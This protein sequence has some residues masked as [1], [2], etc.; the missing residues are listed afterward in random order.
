M[1]KAG[2]TSAGVSAAKSHSGSLAGDYAVTRGVLK[3]AG[4]VMVERSDCLLPV[5]EALTLLPPLLTRRIALLSEGGGVITVAAEALAERGMTLAPLSAETQRKLKAIVPN[6]SALSNPVDA[7][8]GTDPRAEYY[9]Q[10]GRAILED[11]NVDALM[12]TGFFGGYARRYGAEVAATENRVCLE[13]A[14][15]MRSLGKA[16][17]VQSHYAHFRTEAL[18][19]LRKAGIP[20]YRHIEI[21]AQCLASLADYSA[22]QRRLRHAH[23]LPLAAAAAPAIEKILKTASAAQ[24]TALL[25]T[26]ARDLLADV[27]IGMPPTFVLRAAGDAAQAVRK[28]G[29]GPLALKV[30]SHDVL[31]KSDAGG[32]RLGV[33]GEVAI[34]AA[35]SD[36]T[37]AVQQHVPGAVVEG[38]L[39]TP[40]AAPGIELIAGV[41]RDPQFGAVV[42][43]GLGG[44][45]VETI[46][47]VAFRAAPLTREDALEMLAELRFASMLE[48]ARGLPAVDKP[49]LIELLLKLS[50]LVLAHPAVREIDLNPVIAHGNGFTVADARVILYDAAGA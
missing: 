11:P 46:R 5:A 14:E 26:E 8:G 30:V 41:T 10:C 9:G 31:H 20:F 21:A 17:V 27:G 24:R 36:I 47:D 7:G 32:V 22:A 33:A 48:G 43:F 42:L 18:D 28:V 19:I 38:I 45:F 12:F 16:I 13:L 4:V 3:Q 35:F 1:Y 15:L 29:D 23:A 2:R 50:A 44:I 25:E 6:A 39:A 40:M 34:K 49:A 37:R